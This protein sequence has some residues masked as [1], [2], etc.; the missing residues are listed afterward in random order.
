MQVPHRSA[1]PSELGRPDAGIWSKVRARRI[2]LIGAPVALQPSPFIVNTWQNKPVGKVSAV[3]FSALHNG[4][5]LALRLGWA[6]PH[7]DLDLHDNDSFPDG[8]AV[9]FPLRKDATL[10]TMGSVEQPVNAWHW[11]ADRPT[12]ARNNVATG[13][14]SSRVTQGGEISTCAIYHNGHWQ[15]VFLRRLQVKEVSSAVQFAAGQTCKIGFAVWE[16]SNGERGG[17]KAFSPEWQELTL[18]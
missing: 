15:L 11:R 4:E 7:Q 3:D 12:L 8:A 10:A 13:I 18:A 6:D 14:G 2:S 9:I 1:S 5:F 16:G 17:L